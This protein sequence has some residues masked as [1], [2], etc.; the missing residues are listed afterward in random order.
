MTPYLGEIRMFAGSFAPVGWRFCDG[1]LLSIAGNAALYSLLGTTFGGNGT[2]TFALPNLYGRIP[3]GQGTG[4]G[5][6]PATLGQAGGSETVTLLLTN[7]PT[8]THSLNASTTVAASQNPGNN[9]FAACQPNNGGYLSPAAPGGATPYALAQ[10]SVQPSGRSIPHDHMMP[11]VAL[12][13][14][15]SLGGVFPQRP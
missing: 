10:S 9:A 7:L 5:L 1:S 6:S 14:I 2:T 8:H 12:N 15:I 3:V 11:G 13:F 4:S